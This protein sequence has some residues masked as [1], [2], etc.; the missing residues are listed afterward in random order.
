MVLF[1]V[2]IPIKDRKNE[3]KTCVEL[4]LPQIDSSNFELVIIDDGS[5]CD[6][7]DLIEEWGK[8]C[9]VNYIKQVPLGIAVARNRGIAAARG[10]CI[11]FIDSDCFLAKDAFE[12][13]I[14]S[15]EMHPDESS[16]QFKVI[17]DLKSGVG[18]LEFLRLVPTMEYLTLD[19]GHIKYLNT[20]A[21]AIKKDI[22]SE[23]GF[24]NTELVRGEDTDLLGRLL[25]SDRIPLYLEKA[26]AVHSPSMNMVRY[27]IK[28]FRI[29][30]Y[31]ISARASFLPKDRPF[32]NTSDKFELLKR[33]RRLCQ[34]VELSV[35]DFFFVLMAYF[36]EAS[37]RFISRMKISSNVEIQIL[38]TKVHDIDED[39]L[40][41]KMF[42][43]ISQKKGLFITYL[44]AWSLII[45]R[46]D[47]EFRR[48]IETS[49][50]CASDGMGVVI[51][52]ILTKFRFMKKVTLHS[53]YRKLF[54]EI[55]N[56]KIKIALIGGIEGLAEKAAVELKNIEPTIEIAFVNTGYFK[57]ET[58]KQELNGKLEYYKPQIAFI[59]MSQPVQ[60]KWININ[61][62][63]FPEITFY[64]V[65]AFFEFLA[66]KESRLPER[67]V[68]IRKIGF[69]WLWRLIKSPKCLWYR[70]IVGLPL[71][72]VLICQSN[73]IRMI[74]IWGKRSKSS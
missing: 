11:I 30:Y 39:K 32:M 7:H 70:Y 2:V 18:K 51:T 46:K 34:D 29:G 27:I 19:S 59:G 67:L 12:Y 72:F 5:K 10:E 9:S 40:L 38:S 14:K 68:F 26:L 45:S 35:V 42:S 8:V 17:G 37:G 52:A 1:T 49:D 47:Q 21:F 64:C 65:G 13:F 55:A 31:N 3:L 24:F 36:F 53:Y 43:N 23:I 20:S 62:P 66:F 22:F 63:N 56:Q 4:I 57:N 69:E 25:K 48:I 33:M 74:P 60:E 71:L 58:D 16:F 44:T 41:A 54:Q 73:F 50:I 6:F 28:H 15:Y 61:R